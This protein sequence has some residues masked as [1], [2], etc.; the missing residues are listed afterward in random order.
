MKLSLKVTKTYR[1]WPNYGTRLVFEFFGRHK[2]W[3]DF[4]IYR[5]RRCFIS[6]KNQRCLRKIQNQSRLLLR[7]RSACFRQL[8]IYL[9]RQSL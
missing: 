9:V 3:R 8:K 7:P 2:H 5:E 4:S 6:T 1:T